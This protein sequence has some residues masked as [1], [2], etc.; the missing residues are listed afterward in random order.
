MR[1]MID[2]LK[3]IESNTINAETA[4]KA[5]GMDVQTYRL[6]A[7]HNPEK[8]NVP[9]II[10]GNRVKISRTALIRHLESCIVEGGTAA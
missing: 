8:L 10:V 3:E 5:L 1:D 9:V 2:F 4:A 7:K 6:T